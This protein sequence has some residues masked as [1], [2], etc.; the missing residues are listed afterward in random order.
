MI[1]ADVELLVQGKSFV[2]EAHFFQNNTDNFQFGHLSLIE[3]LFTVLS[4]IGWRSLAWPLTRSLQLH[5][6]FSSF[7]ERLQLVRSAPWLIQV[8][9]V[10]VFSIAS[11]KHRVTDFVS[12]LCTHELTCTADID[13]LEQRVE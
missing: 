8:F 9:V 13:A 12:D 3:Y 6:M 11:L 1:P 7:T 5:L 10:G 4:V 2:Q